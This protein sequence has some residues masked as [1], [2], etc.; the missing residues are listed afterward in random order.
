[1]GGYKS[2]FQHGLDSP[3]TSMHIQR[4]TK[5]PPDI[6]LIANWKMYGNSANTVEF[7]DY[8]LKNSHHWPQGTK[9]IFCP[10]AC[11]L[12]V[13]TQVLG[14]EK[15]GAVSVGAQSA[16][17]QQNG[18]HTGDI[19]AVMLKDVGCAYA[20]VG[21]SENRQSRHLSDADVAAEAQAVQQAGLV[22]VI[23][24]GESLEDYTNG[25]AFAVL[26]RQIQAF[27]PH[28][29]GAYL[30]AYEPVWAIGS[31]KTPTL[32]EIEK[33]HQ[34]IKAQLQSVSHNVKQVRDSTP[35]VL[36]GGSVKHD[37]IKN[38]LDL[39]SVDG[40]LIGSASLSVAGFEAVLQAAFNSDK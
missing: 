16:H 29:Q 5:T 12:P 40:A 26:T 3:L 18:A 21:H 37:N 35:P 31:G 22:P 8:L 4:M 19:S 34:H 24:I 9:V 6:T 11:Y 15:R 7:S 27:L 23:C 1:M 2:Q 13:A 32:A 30:L 20:L 38:I 28:M 39:P 36:Y 17:A 14:K 25:Q 33:A 10:P